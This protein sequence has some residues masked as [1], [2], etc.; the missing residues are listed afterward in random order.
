M[1]A[2]ANGFDQLVG[3]GT[4]CSTD[5]SIIEGTHLRKRQKNASGRD[6]WTAADLKC[7]LSGTA[8]ALLGVESTVT[9]VDGDGSRGRQKGGRFYKIETTF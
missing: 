7:V 8:G 6:L 4:I 1:S 5:P 3:V 2:G 9:V